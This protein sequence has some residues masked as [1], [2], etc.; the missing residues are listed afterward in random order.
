MLALEE[1]NFDRGSSTLKHSSS[2]PRD[3]GCGTARALV[4][5]ASFALSRKVDYLEAKSSLLRGFLRCPYWEEP[6]VI[7]TIC[8]T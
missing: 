2:D 7:G 6:I 5:L 3:E 8:I 4:E 1:E